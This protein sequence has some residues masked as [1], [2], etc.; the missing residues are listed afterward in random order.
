VK[1]ARFN[2]WAGRHGEVAMTR[3]YFA[4]LAAAVCL[5]I[6]TITQSQ[7][8]IVAVSGTYTA[9]S[10][11]DTGSFTGTLTITGGAFSAGD[12]LT[13]PTTGQNLGEL[14]VFDAGDDTFIRIFG[15]TS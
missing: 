4:G 3:A 1:L 11:T 8:T 5:L 6:L 7:A 10:S 9:L 14:N 12:I 2:M 15:R 13:T